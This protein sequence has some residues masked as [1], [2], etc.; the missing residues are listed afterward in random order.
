M[1]FVKLCALGPAS[2]SVGVFPT[3]LNNVFLKLLLMQRGEQWPITVIHYFK[4]P[5]AAVI[6]INIQIRLCIQHYTINTTYSVFLFIVC[7]LYGVIGDN[8]A[9]SLHREKLWADFVWGVPH[10]LC[11]WL[12][13]G[14]C[15]LIPRTEL[16]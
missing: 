6:D 4:G 14:N 15:S 2:I 5:M 16:V 11:N 10:N 13:Y 3:Q 12:T 1:P 7:T 8:R 9:V